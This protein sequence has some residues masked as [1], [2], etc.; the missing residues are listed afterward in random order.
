MMM[1]ERGGDAA[2]E[3]QAGRV[4]IILPVGLRRSCAHRAAIELRDLSTHGFRAEVFERLT[5]NE[6]LWL[7]LPGVE[8]WEARVAWVHGDEVGCEFL[9]PL[10]PAVLNIILAQGRG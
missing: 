5:P 2:V 6:R 3:R 7:K 1:S 8:G 10:H 4:K 9:Q